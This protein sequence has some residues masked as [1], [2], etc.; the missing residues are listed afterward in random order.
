[1]AEEEPI[2]TNPPT[3]EVARHVDDY[4]NFTHILKWSAIVCLAIALIVVIFVL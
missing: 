2:L 3:P 4:S 1:M